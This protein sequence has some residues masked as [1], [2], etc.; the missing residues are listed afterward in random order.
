MLGRSG[1]VIRPPDIPSSDRRTSTS[2]RGLPWRVAGAIGEAAPPTAAVPRRPGSARRLPG[3][4]P[5]T[6][7]P[8]PRPA[9]RRRTS[10]LRTQPAR[11]H[12]P[13]ARH[14]LQARPHPQAGR[15]LRAGHRRPRARLPGP[16]AA[17]V[18]CGR[19]TLP[20]RDRMA[21]RRGRQ[22]HRAPART[23]RPRRQAARLLH[24]RLPPPAPPAAAALRPAHRAAAPDRVRGRQPL[25]AVAPAA[26]RAPAPRVP[27]AAPG[28]AWGPG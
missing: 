13:R 26:A 9:R 14:R 7:P 4:P 19:G 3:K 21:P 17:P 18:R 15:R 25:A 12:P 22:R 23:R 16:P 5:T 2:P 24:R 1:G 28:A 27:L 10:P 8:R 6:R 20:A 11:P